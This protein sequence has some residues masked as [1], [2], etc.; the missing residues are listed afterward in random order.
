MEIP[1]KESVYNGNIAYYFSILFKK[2]IIVIIIV[3]LFIFIL[4][5]F[6]SQLFKL[7]I[8]LILYSNI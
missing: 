1:N 3:L 5:K 4:L 8:I 2:R 6:Y 7:Y